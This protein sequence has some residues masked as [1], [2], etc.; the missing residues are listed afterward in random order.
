MSLLN[1]VAEFVKVIAS[2]LGTTNGAVL[3]N[4]VGITAGDD[5][6]GEQAHE[7]ETYG[8][9]GVV[10]RPLPPEGD[11]FAEAL[12]V[13]T[14]DG[15]VP[16][17]WRD[18]RIHRALNPSG[19]PTTPR[20]GQVMFAGYRGAFLSHSMTEGNTGSKPGNVT[21]LYCPYD[22]NGAGVAQKAHAI[23]LD[24]TDGN[25][26]ISVVHGS[27]VFFTLSGDTG[28]GPGIVASVDGSTFLRMSPGELSVSAEKILLKGNVYVGR[29]AEAGAPLLPGIAS[30][31]CM[32]LFLSPV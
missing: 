5:D 16:M 3:A 1:H 13:R 6:T 30:P 22:F 8:A 26:S 27:G 29:Q 21:V 32:S 14:E 4:V 17:A 7:Q 25:E 18:L 20:E 2:S 28:S 31:P 23:I 10:G 24:P 11:A 19:T 9:L 15:L 12:A